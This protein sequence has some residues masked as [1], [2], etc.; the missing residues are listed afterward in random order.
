MLKS[1]ERDESAAAVDLGE[2]RSVHRLHFYV[3]LVVWKWGV[4]TLL[5]TFWSII[6]AGRLWPSGLVAPAGM[7]RADPATGR[8][9]PGQR[10][11]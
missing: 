3:P 8:L 9:R 7:L 10:F 6:S 4:S 1:A 11:N 2:R 5:I